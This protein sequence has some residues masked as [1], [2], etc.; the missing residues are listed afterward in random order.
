MGQWILPPRTCSRTK[1]RNPT[2]ETVEGAQYFDLSIVV[3]DH[4]VLTFQYVQYPDWSHL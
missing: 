3:L 4:P 1:H 2:Y